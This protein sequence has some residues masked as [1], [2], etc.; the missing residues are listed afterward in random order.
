MLQEFK[1]FIFRGDVVALATGVIIGGAFGS[2]VKAFTEGIVNPLL[3]LAGGSP[4][5]DLKIPLGS[6]GAALDV[7]LVIS[8][9][10]SFLI[11]AAIIFFFIV[12][13]A[14]AFMKKIMAEEKAKPSAP[15]ADVVLL[16]E[17]RDELKKSSK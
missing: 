14:T 12:K 15:P 6:E 16:T 8:A 11:T 2:I 4:E 5:I 1:K 7:G 13:P 17:I 10:I 3:A 9:M